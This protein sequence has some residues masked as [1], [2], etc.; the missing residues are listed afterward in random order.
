MN[1]RT[2]FTVFRG[3]V[4][5][6]FRHA[7]SSGV[8]WLMLVVSLASIAL[9]LTLQHVEEPDGPGH[10]DLAFGAVQVSLAQG[11]LVAV[12]TLEGYLAG[13]IADGLGLL[14]ALL[15]TAGFLPSFLESNTAAVLLAKPISRGCL[16]VGKCLGVVA[17]VAV[18]DSLLLG[19]TWLA[20]G[21][22]TGVWDATYL[23]CLPLLLLH[24]AIFFSFSALLATAT[25]STVACVFG[26]VLFW[27]LCWAMNLGRHCYRLLPEL[28]NAAASLHHS[29]ELGYWLLPKPLDCHMILLGT[30]QDD[31]LVPR[32][33]DPQALAA[34]GAWQP[35]ASVL[36]SC[37]CALVLLALAAYD[38]VTAEY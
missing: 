15:W 4:R 5:D 23:L 18:Q 6:T 12:R 22:R 28:H 36:A 21:L 7:H 11:N 38:F 14:L 30:L 9:C 26:S 32:L 25:R 35:A 31:A 29:V 1:P 16:L 20:L 10:L 24:F 17:F 27:L 34:C 8:F 3:L 13:W 37:L 2:T 19:G 33:V